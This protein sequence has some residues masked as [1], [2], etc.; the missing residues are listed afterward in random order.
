[1]DEGASPFE[2]RTPLGCW[3]LYSTFQITFKKSIRNP[4]LLLKTPL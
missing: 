2:G 1:M 3:G 4:M